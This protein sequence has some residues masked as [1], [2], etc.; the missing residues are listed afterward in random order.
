MPS[1]YRMAGGMLRSVADAEDAVQQT[2]LKAWEKHSEIREETFR[3]YVH[4]ILVN[5]CRDMIRRRGRTVPVAEVPDGPWEERGFDSP[6]PALRSALLA[7][8]E[9]LRLPLLLTY[10]EGYSAREIARILRIPETTV[11]NRVFRAKKKLQKVILAYREAE[12]A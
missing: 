9:E 4:R 7:L 3:A 6:D 12:N 2:L 1:L 5:Q 11:R 10:M 8:R